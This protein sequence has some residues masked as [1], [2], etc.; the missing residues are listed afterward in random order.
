MGATINNVYYV[1]LFPIMQRLYLSRVIRRPIALVD[2]PM[3]KNSAANL[4]TQKWEKGWPQCRLKLKT[5]KK[6]D[7]V[8]VF[9][10]V[11]LSQHQNH[12]P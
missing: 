6:H 3:L 2:L 5:I 12:Q 7:V 8:T 9:Y 11:L 10:R 4:L 1:K